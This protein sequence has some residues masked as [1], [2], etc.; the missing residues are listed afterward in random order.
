MCI[1]INTMKTI[2]FFGDS[3]CADTTDDSWC[4]IFADKIGSGD[5]VCYGGKGESIWNTFFKFN[6]RIKQDTVPD[7]SVF[8]WTE[9]YRLY[10]PRMILTANVIPS[11]H[12]DPNVYKALD[13]YWKYLHNYDKDEMAYEYS[14]K[15]YDQNVLAK[16]DKKIIQLWSFRPFETASKDANI[17]LQTGLFVNK[18]LYSTAK[19]DR[20]K[21]KVINHMSKDMNRMLAT[22]LVDVSRQ[23]LQK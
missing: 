20:G 12:E 14:L 17:Q 3:F 6:D 10:H 7:I 8:C 9:P 16:V 19:S 18:S 23:Y 22:Q 15:H 2:G 21:D 5:P 11:K 13:D 4:N 1:I